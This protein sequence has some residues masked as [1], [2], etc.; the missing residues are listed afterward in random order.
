MCVSV[1]A[2]ESVFQSQC[3]AAAVTLLGGHLFSAFS[4]LGTQRSSHSEQ[5]SAIPL[6]HTLLINLVLSCQE[7]KL[8]AS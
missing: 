5:M 3:V 2:W 6:P 8:F 4:P 7:D 1:C